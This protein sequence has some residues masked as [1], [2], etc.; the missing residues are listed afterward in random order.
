[1]EVRIRTPSEMVHSFVFNIC[2]AVW[3]SG[4][5]PIP[6]MGSDM[7]TESGFVTLYDYPVFENGEAG[8]EPAI[9]T[10]PS[11]DNHG[12]YYGKLPGISGQSR[13]SFPNGD[14]L[15]I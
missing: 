2:N 10:F 12:F 7:N 1:M 13:G 15:L 14:R 4:S 3:D 8:E 9:I 6:C 11:N 5:G